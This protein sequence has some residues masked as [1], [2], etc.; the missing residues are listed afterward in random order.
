M[1]KNRHYRSDRKTP[2]SLQ[3]QKYLERKTVHL[4]L[5]EKIKQSN[6][7]TSL[8]PDFVRDF[9]QKEKLAPIFFSTFSNT[10]KMCNADLQKDFITLLS[11]NLNLF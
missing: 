11:Q 6:Y 4:N 2:N 3:L 10:S 5:L 1:P 9:L 8:L 7:E